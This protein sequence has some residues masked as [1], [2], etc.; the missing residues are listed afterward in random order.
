[1]V[2]ENGEATAASQEKATN[3]QRTAGTFS[4]DAEQAWIAANPGIVRIVLAAYPHFG[5]TVLISRE[6][7]RGG[8]QTRNNC[9][10]C[11]PN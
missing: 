5:K 11:E 8:K 2:V 6:E 3:R 10:K 1:M 4:Q 7:F 9:R